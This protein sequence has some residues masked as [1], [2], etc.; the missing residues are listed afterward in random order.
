LS[1]LTHEE[2]VLLE[3]VALGELPQTDLAV[4]TRMAAN[5]AFQAEIEELAQMLKTLREARHAEEDDLAAARAFVTDDD[6]AAIRRAFEPR[7]AHEAARRRL[8]RYGLALTLVAAL[9]LAFIALRPR[10]ER[11]APDGLLGP[12]APAAPVGPAELGRFAVELRLAAHETIVFV[13]YDA[14]G[15]ECLRSPALTTPTWQ[16]APAEAARLPERLR[17]LYEIHDA[18]GN[19]RHGGPYEAWRAR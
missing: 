4:R 14:A 12:G 1:G 5:P 16:L 18:A 8:R 9:V 3:R 13:V 10:S 19:V 7:L 6:R 17:W 11:P 15:S 2:L